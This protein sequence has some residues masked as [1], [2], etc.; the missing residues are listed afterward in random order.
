MAHSVVQNTAAGIVSSYLHGVGLTQPIAVGSGMSRGTLGGSLAHKEVDESGASGVVFSGVCPVSIPA[1]IQLDQSDREFSLEEEL[2]PEFGFSQANESEYRRMAEFIHLLYPQSKAL[3][4]SIP[5]NQAMFKMCSTKPSVLQTSSKLVQFGR[6]LPPVPT[7]VKA[8]YSGE[9]LKAASQHVNQTLYVHLDPLAQAK[10]LGAKQQLSLC[11]HIITSLYSQFFLP[12]GHGLDVRVL[13]AGFK[14]TS[15]VP[16]KTKCE[17]DIVLFDR[18]RKAVKKTDIEKKKR[19]KSFLLRCKSEK[20]ILFD[21]LEGS[22]S[23][24]P[25]NVVNEEANNVY[26]NVVLG[27]TFD[28]IHDGHKILLSEALLRCTKRLTV[29]VADGPLLKNKTLKELIEP[30]EVRINNVKDLLNDFR[31]KCRV[32]IVQILDPMGPAGWDK[33]LEMIVVSEETKKGITL[34]NNARQESGLNL[35]DGYIICLVNDKFRASDEEEMKLSASSMRMRLLGTILKPVESNYALS[36]HILMFIGLTG[37]SASGKSSVAKRF[38][39]LGA[40]VVDCDKLGHEAYLKGSKCYKDLIEAF[41]SD[42]VGKDGQIDRRVLGSK[43]FNDKSALE[44]LNSIVWPEIARLAKE[45]I[46]TFSRE[47]IK[48]VILDAAVL[49]EADWDKFCHQVW[50]C[51]IKRDEAVRRIVERDGKST[52]EAE[53][54]IDSQISNEKRVSCANIVFCTQWSGDYTQ[55]QCEKAWKILQEIISKQETIHGR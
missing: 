35:L 20:I 34:I 54:R 27:G 48:V 2:V 12:S 26:S 11:S 28:C 16:L 29:G 42:V 7:V 39:K 55:K 19:Y 5:P 23:Q 40:G 41:G 46:D 18:L 50:V 10:T 38:A 22:E 6:L 44:Q 4:E 37:G 1:L 43:V 24:P 21:N 30:C 32:V 8:M 15:E 36:F 51:I 17:I 47:G 52:E 31:S 14:G 33:S 53:R 25:E 13:M 49:L 3:E 45:R 9:V